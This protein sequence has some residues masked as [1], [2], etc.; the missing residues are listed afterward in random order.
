VLLTL[1]FATLGVREIPWLGKA[2]SLGALIVWFLQLEAFARSWWH[3]V[4]LVLATLFVSWWWQ[5]RGR[6]LIPA[7][8]VRWVQAIAAAASMTILLLWV[9]SRVAR[10]PVALI[11][12]SALAVAGLLFA[13][14]MR[15]RFL[16]AFSQLFTIAAVGEFI[17]QLT[18]APLPGA[19]A[20]LAPVVALPILAPI[21]RKLFADTEWDKPVR[22]VAALY[23]ALAAAM[24]VVWTLHFIAPPNRFVTL[25]AIAMLLLLCTVAAH[26]RG[27]LLASLVCSTGALLAFWL[28][29]VGHAGFRWRDL[30]AFILL[31]GFG[32]LGRRT[33]VLPEPVQQMGIVLGLGSV[34]H[35]VSLWSA[36]HWPAVPLAAVWSVVAVI[37]IT[38][39]WWLDEPLYRGTAWALLGAALLHTCLAGAPHAPAFRAGLLAVGVASVIAAASGVRR[40]SI[41][42]SSSPE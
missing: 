33:R 29:W 27:P 16:A 30:L 21:T 10:E 5:T 1:S 17:G 37:I 11:A 42:I 23:G 26:P 8:E 41:R 9:E 38:L 4:V 28:G 6:T 25:A 14:A 13:V 22:V 12:M 7:W 39:G 34:V 35:W 31:L 15:D 40:R 2:F 20:A 19:L 36:H 24:L 18:T 3:P 32:A